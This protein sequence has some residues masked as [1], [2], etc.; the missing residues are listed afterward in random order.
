MPNAIL[1]RLTSPTS[2]MD[3]EQELLALGS[4]AVPIL[5]SVLKGEAANEFGVPYRKLGLPLRCVLEVATRLGPLARPLEALLRVELHGGHFVAA[6]A[7]GALGSVENRSIEELAAH[8]DYK[9]NQLSSVPHALDLA[10]ECAV[11]LIRLD[12]AKHPV[13]LTALE[14]SPRATA[15]FDRMMKFVLCQRRASG[16]VE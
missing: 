8:L 7:L 4:R 9:A 2:M 10:T 5:E 13:V 6:Q 12:H 14:G 11:A 16:D 3:A 1:D 15:D